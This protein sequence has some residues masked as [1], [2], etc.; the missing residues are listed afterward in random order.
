M[1][2]S[3][4]PGWSDFF[5]ATAGVA[6]A[7]AGLVFVSISINLE[8][9]L[10]LPSAINRAGE[11]LIVLAGVLA[12]ALILLVPA[13]SGHHL[14]EMLLFA[15]IPVWLLPMLIQLRTFRKRHYQ[16]VLHI[17][18]RAMLHQ[19]ATLPIL[20]GSLGLLGTLPT[21]GVG[22]IGAG[23]ILSMLVAMFS[24]W[25]LLIEILR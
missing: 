10:K 9:V 7:L 22:W 13:Q 21:F 11:T 19:M 6:G 17:P 1:E 14:G 3:A 18:F 12:V 20:L 16:H 24:A 2:T 5:V 15:A 25:V 23:C 4:I 8:K